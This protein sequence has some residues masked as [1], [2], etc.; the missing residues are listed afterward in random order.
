MARFKLRNLAVNRVSL[1]DQGANQFSRILLAKNKG[2]SE[3][4]KPEEETDDKKKKKK[5]LPPFM[6]EKMSKSLDETIT[7]FHA[8][9]VDAGVLKEESTPSDLRDILPAETLSSI[10]SV[11]KSALSA[12]PTTGDE[13]DLEALVD[14]LPEEVVDYVTDLETKVKDLTK[15]LEDAEKPAPEDEETDPVAKALATLPAEAVELFKAQSDRLAVAEKELAESKIAKANETWIAKAR[16]FDGVVEK[17]E[18]F[19]VILREVADIK[20][21]L[22]ASIE[23]A[24][25]VAAERVTKGD[26]FK[27]LGHGTAPAS[28]IESKVEQLA[29]SFIEADAKLSP[30]AARAKVWQESPELYDEYLQEQ[31]QNAR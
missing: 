7:N 28:D 17:P 25:K 1:V 18:E 20:P 29:K 5:S 3:E 16:A 19:G 24:L 22:A 6:Q 15:R 12:E 21:E 2:K 26:L 31:R 4:E 13:M 27:E 30:S 14:Q 11:L 8:G 10:E 23:T 9:L